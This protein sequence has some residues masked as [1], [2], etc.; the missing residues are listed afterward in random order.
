MTSTRTL[1]P[2]LA[3]SC[4]TSMRLPLVFV[5]LALLAG[6]PL[7]A[8]M[9]PGRL[10]PLAPGTRVRV[11]APGLSEWDYRGS[12]WALSADTLY[13]AVD[14]ELRHAIAR[15]EIEGVWVSRGRTAPALIGGGV[16]ALLFGALGVVGLYLGEAPASAR[17]ENTF[18]VGA[19]ATV[20]GALGALLGAAVAEPWRRV[21][22]RRGAAGALQLLPPSG[23]RHGRMME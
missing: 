13:L 1:A 23:G 8:Q 19:S 20:G 9:V 21:Y 14:G 7:S 10:A 12:V 16:G 18:K 2:L 3:L 11:S 15:G 4:L 6:A 17:V 22:L 5:A